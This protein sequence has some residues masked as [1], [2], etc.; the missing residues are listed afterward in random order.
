M[1]TNKQEVRATIRT[2]PMDRAMPNEFDLIDY[3]KLTAEYEAGGD[4]ADSC[5]KIGDGPGL[6]LTKASHNSPTFINRIQKS[7]IVVEIAQFL[8][9]QFP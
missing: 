1:E 4:Y 8:N 5:F 6:M 2:G 9:L 3:L 7:F